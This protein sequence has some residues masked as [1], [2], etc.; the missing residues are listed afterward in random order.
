MDDVLSSA[1][2]VRLGRAYRK[3]ED[4]G[5]RTGSLAC[6]KANWI[7]SAVGSLLPQFYLDGSSK[8]VLSNAL[9]SDLRCTPAVWSMS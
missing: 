1:D 4:W 6:S 8:Q 9:G 5:C 2:H 3:S 7:R